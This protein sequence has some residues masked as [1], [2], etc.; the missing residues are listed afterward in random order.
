M[1]R[2][3]ETGAYPKKRD[4]TEPALESGVLTEGSFLEELSAS[5][6]YEFLR[7]YITENVGFTYAVVQLERL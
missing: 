2:M 6:K 1:T 7:S 4:L 5:F 3:D